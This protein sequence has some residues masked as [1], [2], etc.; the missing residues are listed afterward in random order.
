MEYLQPLLRTLCGASGEVPTMPAISDPRARRPGYG[1]DRDDPFL[2]ILWQTSDGAVMFWLAYG[3][4][5]AYPKPMK[6][7]QVQ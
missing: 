1:L 5:P 3:M 4:C 6:A 7:F 2:G